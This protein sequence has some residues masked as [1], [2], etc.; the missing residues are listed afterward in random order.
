MFFY[1][2]NWFLYGGDVGLSGFLWADFPRPVWNGTTRESQT[3]QRPPWVKMILWF[4]DDVDDYI[5]DD[6]DDY[7]YDNIDDGGEVN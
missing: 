7:I 3:A 5:D 6:V 4:Y 2:L 1:C